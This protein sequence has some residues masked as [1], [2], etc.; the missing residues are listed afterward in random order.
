MENKF[1]TKKKT[2]KKNHSKTWTRCVPTCP[3]PPLN[4]LHPHLCPSTPKH[5]HQHSFLLSYHHHPYVYSTY[6]P[7]VFSL[8][9]KKVKMTPLSPPAP[10]PVHPPSKGVEEDDGPSVFEVLNVFRQQWFLNRDHLIANV[11]STQKD[12]SG[13]IMWV[14]FLPAFHT[15]LVQRALTLLPPLCPIAKGKRCMF[16][17]VLKVLDGDGPGPSGPGSFF[18][19]PKKRTWSLPKGKVAL[20][21]LAPLA[22]PSLPLSCPLPSSPITAAPS[23]EVPP[24]PLKYGNKQVDKS[25]WDWDVAPGIAA[26]VMQSTSPSLLSTLMPSLVV[27]A[28]VPLEPSV[29]PVMLSQ[30]EDILAT[31]RMVQALHAQFPPPASSS[32]S[33][34][35]TE[36][37]VDEFPSP[38]HSRAA[39]LDASF[40]PW[41]DTHCSPDPWETPMV[42]RSWIEATLLNGIPVK[43]LQTYIQT[44][45][46]SLPSVG[47]DKWMHIH[48]KS[49]N[50]VIDALDRW[51]L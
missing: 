13:H 37:N 33:S 3:L 23:L 2:K 35:S 18:T 21:A 14:D 19:L 50:S 25:T 51:H 40:N 12:E 44:I 29:S 5:C 15:H 30:V 8:P 28:L 38:S 4:L 17:F 34:S 10:G 7:P 26:V 32:T 47:Q 9:N 43:G 1:V 46:S 24:L 45:G 49:I 11:L 42:W 22:P 48:L 6:F 39:S 20:A 41:T 16:V 31:S 36:M 27:G